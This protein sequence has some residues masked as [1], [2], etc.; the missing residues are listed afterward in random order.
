MMRKASWRL[1]QAGKPDVLVRRTFALDA[2]QVLRLLYIDASYPTGNG[3]QVSQ[4]GRTLCVTRWSNTAVDATDVP[5]P[6]RRN[7]RDTHCGTTKR[8][9]PGYFAGSRMNEL[10]SNS[11][12]YAE[13]KSQSVCGTGRSGR[14]AEPRDV[15]PADHRP[16]Q[17]R[18]EACTRHS[19]RRA[20]LGQKRPRFVDSLSAAGLPSRLWNPVNS[21]RELSIEIIVCRPPPQCRCQCWSPCSRASLSFAA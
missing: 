6:R 14:Y 8:I 15:L 19:A 18:V 2:R 9:G 1:C 3:M 13:R 10:I 21:L 7:R 12:S 17:Y 16:Y 5:N 20:G 11:E 4:A